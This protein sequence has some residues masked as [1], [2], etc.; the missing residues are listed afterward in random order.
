M[1]RILLCT[2]GEEQTERAERR[3]LD[4]ARRYDALLVGLYVVNPFPGKFTDEV[5]AV[6]R[7]ESRDHPDRALREEGGKAL[8]ALTHA[9]DADGVR[10]EPK[11]RYGDPEEEILKE[12][13]EGNYDILILGARLLKGW[14]RRTG[15]S[16]LPR[17]MLMNAPIPILFVR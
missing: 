14:R 3:A 11:M 1:K 8:M 12:I 2:D 17:K 7:Q 4:L 16:N 6:N 13:E 5:Y 10:F 15:S 9:C